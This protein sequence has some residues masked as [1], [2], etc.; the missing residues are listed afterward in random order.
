MRFLANIFPHTPVYILF[1]FSSWNFQY[2]STICLPVYYWFQCC[3]KY[4][5]PLTLQQGSSPLRKRSVYEY[6]IHQ[7]YFICFLVLERGCSESVIGRW[8]AIYYIGFGGLKKNSKLYMPLI[9]LVFRRSVVSNFKSVALLTRKKNPFHGNVIFSLLLLLSWK[10][11]QRR[12][13]RSMNS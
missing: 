3:F 5:L 10:F 11:I 9:L 12:C 2:I 1:W 7:P 13:H 6:L 4:S 8:V